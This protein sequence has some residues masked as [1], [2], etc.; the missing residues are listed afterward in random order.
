MS[1][2]LSGTPVPRTAEAAAACPAFTAMSHAAGQR[3]VLEELLF[4]RL[5]SPGWGTGMARGRGQLP[6]S[7][8]RMAVSV[9]SVCP[10]AFTAHF[11]A[12]R[13]ALS[14]RQ[15]QSDAVVNCRLPLH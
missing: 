5:T 2:P 14:R 4:R 6:S 3:T 11:S 8:L 9:A 7:P 10:E 12:G 13:I 1:C 15:Q